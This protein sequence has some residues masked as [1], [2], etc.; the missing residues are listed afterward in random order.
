M[1][2]L[3]SESL[4]EEMILFLL[5]GFQSWLLIPRLLRIPWKGDNE[6]IAGDEDDSAWGARV[7]EADDDAFGDDGD[8]EAGEKLQPVSLMKNQSRSW[9]VDEQEEDQVERQHERETEE[10]TNFFF[11]SLSD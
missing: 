3:S 2:H 8:G 7:D 11:P 9:Y 10:K 5:K 6:E 1:I 4:E